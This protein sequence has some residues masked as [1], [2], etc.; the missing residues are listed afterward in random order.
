MAKLIFPAHNE[1]VDINKIKLGLPWAVEYDEDNDSD[2]QSMTI[3]VSKDGAPEDVSDDK[4]IK[5]LTYDCDSVYENCMKDT[6]FSSLSY[7]DVSPTKFEV[8]K[9]Y[10]W[11]IQYNVGG[12]L[13]WDDSNK[14][15][16]IDPKI[17]GCTDP[18][19]TNYTY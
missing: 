5:S 2:R 19:A 7:W 17:P 8:G 6:G 15:T 18:K 1:E 3:Y 14:F 13:F 12:E 16:F 11:N 10:Y 9:T 4:I